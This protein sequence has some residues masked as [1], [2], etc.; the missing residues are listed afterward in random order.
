MLFGENQRRGEGFLA[1]E[2]FRQETSGSAVH[3]DC[4][5]QIPLMPPASSKISLQEPSRSMDT[6]SLNLDG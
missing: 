2:T 1:L 3:R 5:T 6:D 4:W